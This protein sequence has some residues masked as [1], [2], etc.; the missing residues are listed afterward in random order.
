MLTKELF[1][2]QKALLDQFLRTGAINQ[3]Q[4]DKS[5]AT[6]KATFEKDQAKTACQKDD[7]VVK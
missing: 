2:K 6:L 3:A 7:F 1:E 5:F 4:Y